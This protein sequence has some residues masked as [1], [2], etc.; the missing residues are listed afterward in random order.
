MNTEIKAIEDDLKGLLLKLYGQPRTREI[1]I[2]ITKI[3]EALMWFEKDVKNKQ[4][5][6]E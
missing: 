2:V 6:N 5:N 4:V 3:E 1:S